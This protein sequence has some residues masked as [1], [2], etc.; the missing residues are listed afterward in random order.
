MLYRRMNHTP[1]NGEQFINGSCVYGTPDQVAERIRPIVEMGIGNIIMSFNN[2]FHSAEQ[3]RIT[4]RSMRL[5]A[6]EVMPR[7]KDIAPPADPSVF[8]EG[9]TDAPSGF[10]ERREILA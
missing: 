2:G 8:L 6:A 5:F 1:F 9:E 10:T 3:T 7:F 4:E